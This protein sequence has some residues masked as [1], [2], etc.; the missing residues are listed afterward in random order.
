MRAHRLAAVTILSVAAAFADDQP[1]PARAK[2]GSVVV[3]QEEGGLE[4]DVPLP[5]Q[6]SLRERD[7][8][9]DRLLKSLPDLGTEDVP[10]KPGWTEKLADSFKDQLKN[11]PGECEPSKCAAQEATRARLQ[12]MNPDYGPTDDWTW[13]PPSR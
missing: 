5:R 1:P 9:F 2:S 13:T 10:F 12:Q 3:Q 11:G 6:R 7:P 4:F 8:K